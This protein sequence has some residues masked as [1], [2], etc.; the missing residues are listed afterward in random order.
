MSSG[1]F[2]FKVVS[3]K[4]FKLSSSLSS[5]IEFTHIEKRCNDMSGG[6]ESNL[7]EMNERHFEKYFEFTSII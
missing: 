6:K 1:S 7:L 5:D 4:I 2:G 3:I